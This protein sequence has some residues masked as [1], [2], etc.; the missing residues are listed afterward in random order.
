MPDAALHSLRLDTPPGNVNLVHMLLDAVWASAPDIPVEERLRFE[1]AL[2]ELAANVIKHSTSSTGVSCLLSVS[3]ASGH[4]EA[5]LSDTADPGHVELV[6][7]V[8]PDDLS[9]SG[10]GI[11]LI[12]A[13]VDELE[14]S[15]DGSH[16]QW[17]ISRRFSA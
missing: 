15:H 13:L 8:M 16:N 7:R 2:I 6:G 11:P 5:V 9:E 12:Q 10:R 4:L 14:Y 3:T 1:T 17:R